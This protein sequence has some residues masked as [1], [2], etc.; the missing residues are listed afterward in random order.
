MIKKSKGDP[1]GA[2]C[3]VLIDEEP[4]PAWACELQRELQNTRA[5]L[6]RMRSALSPLVMRG[7]TGLTQE[8]VKALFGMAGL[9]S[10]VAESGL[11]KLI[12]RSDKAV[13]R[14]FQDWV[15]REVLPSIR[16]TG[17]YLLNEEMRATAGADQSI[18]AP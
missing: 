14:E 10:F 9:L 18:T 4:A 3:H 7:L 2:T 6:Q 16:K 12:M 13:A 17:G 11:F 8:T 5:G 15:T 1:K